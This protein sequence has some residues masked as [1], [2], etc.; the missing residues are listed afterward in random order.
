M[1][2]HPFGMARPDGCRANAADRK[3][4]RKIFSQKP[5]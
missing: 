4:G 3:A 2:T 5:A 1:N